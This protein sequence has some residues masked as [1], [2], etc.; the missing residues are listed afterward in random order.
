M[1]SS[2]TCQRQEAVLCAFEAFPQYLTTNTVRDSISL[3]YRLRNV[4]GTASWSGL[5]T[6]KDSAETWRVFMANGSAIPE[7]GILVNEKHAAKI[8]SDD[9]IMGKDGQEIKAQFI[10]GRG[11]N[12]VLGRDNGF[13]P[14]P[15]TYDV[16]HSP[17]ETKL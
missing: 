2:L 10:V 16:R 6:A 13:V 5:R 12:R 8:V 3:K 14:V 17:S 1:L 15:S 9:P 11:L 7:V 4:D